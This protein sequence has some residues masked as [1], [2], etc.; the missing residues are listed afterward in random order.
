MSVEPCQWLRINFRTWFLFL[1]NL[2]LG[3][4]AGPVG[5]QIPIWL[6]ARSVPFWSYCF[7]IFP[8]KSSQLSMETLMLVSI[9]SNKLSGSLVIVAACPGCLWCAVN[10]SG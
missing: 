6:L 10:G 4:A 3:F 9:A 2:L 5:L 8:E 1:P 7:V